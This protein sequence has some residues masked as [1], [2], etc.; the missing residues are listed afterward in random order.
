MVTELVMVTARLFFSGGGG[1]GGPT[2]IVST[3][4]RWMRRLGGLGHVQRRPRP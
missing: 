2:G 4:R 1:Y 3:I